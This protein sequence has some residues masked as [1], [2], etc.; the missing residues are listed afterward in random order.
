LLRSIPSA[1][2][3]ITSRWPRAAGAVRDRAHLCGVS[4]ISPLIGVAAL[5][6]SSAE[7][8]S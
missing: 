3:L 6:W 7:L 1:V 8:L 4:I 2:A 5:A